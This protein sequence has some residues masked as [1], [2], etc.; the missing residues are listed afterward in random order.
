MKFERLVILIVIIVVVITIFMYLGV[1][2]TEFPRFMALNNVDK[3]SLMK[4]QRLE[5]LPKF[6]NQR[7]VISL[8]TIPQRID[9]IA[10]T[11]A[12]LMDQTVYVDEISVN[13]PLISRKGIE[14]EIPKWLQDLSDS[15]N[16]NVKIHRVE[17]DEG[18]AT[19]LLPTLRRE[20][21]PAV[22]NGLQKMKPLKVD[23]KPSRI[24]VARD[25]ERLQVLSSNSPTA[26]I[27]VDDDMVYHP[28][29][30]FNLCRTFEKYGKQHAV[31]NFGV[32]LDKNGKLP[33]DWQRPLLY[34]TGSHEVDIVN[35]FS[36]FLVTP[37][38]FPAQVFDY[39]NAPKKAISVDDVWFSGWLRYNGI[40]IM[41][42][43]R[44]F[45]CVSIPSISGI[46]ENTPC[47]GG[48]ENLNFESDYAVINWF[49]NEIGLK[50]VVLT[51]RV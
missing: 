30:V 50:P 49:R 35:G 34:F 15:P 1:C 27:V 6:E 23:K 43:P 5:R 8:S 3:H 24:R 22:G 33:K 10:P 36:A 4:P 21:R 39:S 37:E 47:L 18:P 16:H 31:T 46:R 38:M 12:S 51:S 42:S 2:L 13:I 11:I 25:G 48:T 9:L 44:L 20:G 41:T 19:K 7:V 14:Y 17:V 40:R 45:T 28:Q 32:R 29:A 26:I